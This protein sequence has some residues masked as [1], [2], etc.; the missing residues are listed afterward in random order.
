MYKVTAKN[1]GKYGNVKPGERY[2]VTKRSA[3]QVA[4]SFAKIECDYSVEKWTRL[5]SDV[6][7]WSD[8]EIASDIWVKINKAL[9]EEGE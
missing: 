4:V 6:F 2:C 5:H 9:E 1:R 8:V 7:A 3:V